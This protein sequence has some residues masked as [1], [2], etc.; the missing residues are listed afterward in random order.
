M[1][2]VTTNDWWA[3]RPVTE[4]LRIATKLNNN[5]PVYSPKQAT[6]IWLAQY[7]AKRKQVMD[8]ASEK[9]GQKQQPER[10]KR[11]TFSF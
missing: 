10:K 7:E 9:H 2:K 3:S 1:T 8:H 4:K 5:T 11:H 6:E